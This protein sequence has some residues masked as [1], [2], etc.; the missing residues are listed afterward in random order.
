[1]E[2]FIKILALAGIAESVWATFARAG[3]TGD[4]R[5]RPKRVAEAKAIPYKWYSP[6]AQEP[7]PTNSAVIQSQVA[8][9][10]AL[11]SSLDLND[12]R[13]GSYNAALIAVVQNSWISLLSLSGA[14]WKAG[15]L[16]VLEFKLSSDGRVSDLKVLKSTVTKLQSSVCEDAGS[17]PA[18][19]AHWSS[20]RQEAVGADSQIV[21]FTFRYLPDEMQ[22]Q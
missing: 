16:V 18:P 20:D 8:L 5:E 7:R 1:M 6:D 10:A 12:E 4:E 15:G 13:I 2:T 17:L 3:G 11:S 21:S 14:S 19:F 9:H 22:N